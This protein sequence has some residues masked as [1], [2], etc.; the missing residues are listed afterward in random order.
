LR[1]LVVTTGRTR[2]LVDV[3]LPSIRGPGKY[4]GDILIVDYDLDPAAGVDLRK[5]P[6]IILHDSK[7]VYPYISSDRIRAFHE[8]LRDLYSVY[9]VIMVVDG[10]DVEFLAPIEPLLKMG[11]EKLCYNTE[12][13][14]NASWI[15]LE[16]FP[17]A[18]AI[19]DTIK[20]Q[21]IVNAGMFVAPAAQMRDTLQFM[22][23]FLKGTNGFGADQLALNSLVYYHR[24][25]S[26]N[27][28][29]RWNCDAREIA[30]LHRI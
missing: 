12:N 26:E 6:N 4:Q 9:N 18:D 30:I 13:R 8:A 7:R 25:P 28:G 21:L 23:L 16:G 3:W 2:P 5:Q 22:T 10:N 11:E 14:T 24:T 27:V 15:P 1:P 29:R 17:E 20:D 19:W